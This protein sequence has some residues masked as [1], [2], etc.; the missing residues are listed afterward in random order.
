[1]EDIN[2]ILLQTENESLKL[3]NESFN[4]WTINDEFYHNNLIQLNNKYIL[5][6]NNSNFDTIEKY[7]YKTTMFHLNNKC[8]I[9]DKNTHTIEFSI[10]NEFNIFKT[11][12]NKKIKKYPVFSILTFLDDNYNPVIFTKIDTD[13][14][15]YKEIEDENTFICIKPI[16][17]LQ[18]SFD[19]SKYY[20]FYRTDKTI[21]NKILKI[22]IWDE[23]IDENFYNS[24]CENT[25]YNNELMIYQYNKLLVSK[26]IS[27][28]CN[29]DIIECE[30][31]KEL[32]I[33]PNLTNRI[34]ETIIHKN[35]INLF[36][37]EEDNNII[38]INNIFK[39]Y[40]D[41]LMIIITNTTS[42][43]RDITYLE[44]IYGDIANDIYPFINNDM[45]Y[46]IDICNNRFY[47]NIILQKILSKE[48]CYW[49]INESEKNNWELSSYNNY[50]TYLNV[51]KMPSILNFL[52]FISKFWL[53]EIQNIYDCKNITLNITD[54]FISK[55]T[56]E[57]INEN[58]YNDGTFLSL[59]IFLNDHTE[60]EIIFKD[61][62]EKVRI[63]QGDM[64]IY[65]GKKLRSPGSI[66]NGVKY[67]LILLIDI[68]V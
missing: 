29:N 3:D 22:N 56:T 1:M 34:Y 54:M 14:Y 9:F 52:F 35:I 47:K 36:L 59:N 41:S 45:D 12:Y 5:N 32:F 61:N 48:I 30:K 16:K 51:E 37:Y 21:N 4:I 7:L 44:D 62:N 46:L 66:S 20:G 8:I 26:T 58:I 24:S 50:N 65:N 6:N 49:I 53:L 18:I 64:L 17:N 13:S 31:E 39:K 15:K 27:G 68:M 19:S 43:Y 25:I 57:N 38:V 10:I 55:Y 33:V 42:Q 67:I 2:N 40:H 23:N 63:N 28:N 60:G 11:E